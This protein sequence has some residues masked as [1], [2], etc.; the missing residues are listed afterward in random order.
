[1]VAQHQPE[2]FTMSFFE[3]MNPPLVGN[4]EQIDKTVDALK[5]IEAKCVSRINVTPSVMREIIKALTSNLQKYDEAR[6][7]A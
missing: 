6:K 1:M 7:N 4:Q 3:V 5:D 2:F